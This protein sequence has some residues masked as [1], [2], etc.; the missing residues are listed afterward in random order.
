MLNKKTEQIS[1][2]FLLI[3]VI[4]TGCKKNY[5]ANTIEQEKTPVV[6][7]PS[8]QKT[9][10]IIGD[11]IWVRDYPKKGKVVL[12]LN[13]GNRCVVLDTSNIDT[14]RGYIDYWYQ[15]KYKDTIGWVFGSQTNLMTT[16]SKNTDLFLMQMETFINALKIRD[17]RTLNNFIYPNEPVHC[18]LGTSGSDHLRITIT[19]D[20]EKTYK[21]YYD[22][23]GL[24]DTL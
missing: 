1:L 7:S 18:L 19:E 23:K 5:K 22:V 24:L 9:L 3:F 13:Q 21:N 12:K 14:T 17:F 10:T 4:F 15:I 20:L 6:I 2:L 8:K 16:D 11:N